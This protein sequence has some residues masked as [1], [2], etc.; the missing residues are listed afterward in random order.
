MKHPHTDLKHPHT[1]QKHPRTNQKNPH[2]DLKH[3]HTG[4]KH[5]HTDLKRP[6]THMKHD[7]VEEQSLDREIVNSRVLVLNDV[8]HFF[9]NFILELNTGTNLTEFYA[10]HL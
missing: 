6:H 2:T 9:S 7:V 10:Q 8:F 5:L 1:N 4:L 3:P